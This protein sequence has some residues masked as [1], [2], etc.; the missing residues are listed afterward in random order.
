MRQI[1]SPV[2]FLIP[3]ICSNSGNAYQ[4]NLGMLGLVLIKLFFGD[5][6]YVLTPQIVTLC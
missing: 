6:G 3:I 2:F 4:K 5:V 1:V